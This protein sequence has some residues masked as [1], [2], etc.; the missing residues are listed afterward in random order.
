LVPG[1]RL[2]DLA[3]RRRPDPERQ[4]VFAQI[5][6]PAA[7]EY[8]LVD[9]T[10]AKSC[11]DDRGIG[12]CAAESPRQHPAVLEELKTEAGASSGLRTASCGW[13]GAV[14]DGPDEVY[15]RA[16]AR[17]ELKRHRGNR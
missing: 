1:A 17:R 8:E 5:S 2:G 3:I 7:P 12:I 9:F 11:S 15:R 14:A 6:R 13:C 16:I 10:D 4:F